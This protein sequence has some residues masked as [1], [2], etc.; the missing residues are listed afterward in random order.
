MEMSK[1]QIP[2]ATRHEMNERLCHVQLFLVQLPDSV[3]SVSLI[4]VWSCEAPWST[5]DCQTSLT[6]NGIYEASGLALWMQTGAFSVVSIKRESAFNDVAE[7]IPFHVLQRF[8]DSFFSKSVSITS[9]ISRAGKKQKN[10]ERILWPCVMMCV[11]P[12]CKSASATHFD[13]TMTVAS[14]HYILWAWYLAMFRA[15]RDS[16]LWLQNESDICKC[17]L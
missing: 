11:V 7:D 17:Q 5:E 10:R 1:L 8:E 2:V 6:V 3:S 15:I 13:G 12:D 4:T 16:A 14:G 9:A